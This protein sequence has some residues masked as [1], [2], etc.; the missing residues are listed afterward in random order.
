MSEIF[1]SELP[2]KGGRD[3]IH[4]TDTYDWCIEILPHFVNV[5]EIS[6]LT[7]EFHK[8][9]RTQLMVGFAREM[10]SRFPDSTPA[11]SLK[12]STAGGRIDLPL[13]E[14][15]E[16]PSRRVPYDEG[17]VEDGALVSE[18]TISWSGPPPLTPIETLVAMTK[19]LHHTRFGAQ[20][21]WVF[22]KL[23]LPGPFPLSGWDESAQVRIT[24]HLANRFSASDIVLDG[25][26]FGKIYFSVLP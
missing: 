18:E 20:Q 10:E 24:Q 21:K 19:V 26:P 6:R 9:A 22:A 7:L 4:G 2:F 14:C 8:M 17:P 11:Y 5:S 1:V 13:H 23:D 15:G 25:V 16:S 12:I 3:Y